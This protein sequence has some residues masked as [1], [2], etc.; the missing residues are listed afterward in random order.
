[1]E[2]NGDETRVEMGSGLVP[3]WN[4][5]TRECLND[6]FS[7]LT[8]EQRWTGPMLVCKTLMNVCQDPSLNTIVDL[9]TPFL[10]IPESIDLWTC[11]FEAK[12]DSILR[13]VVDRSEGGVTEIRVRHCTNQSLSYVAERCPNLEVLWVKYCPNVTDTSMMKIASNCPMLRELDISYSYGISHK[14]LKMFGMKCKNLQVMKKNLVDPSEFTR[15]EHTGLVPLLYSDIPAPPSLGD[16]V[17]IAVGRHMPQLKHLELQYSTITRESVVVL[18]RGCPNLEYVDILGCWNL[19]SRDIATQF[20]SLKNATIKDLVSLLIS[21]EHYLSSLYAHIIR[22]FKSRV[23]G[24]VQ[25]YE[26]KVKEIT[27]KKKL[28]FLSS[29]GRKKT[30]QFSTFSIKMGSRRGPDWSELIRECLIDIFSRLSTEQKWLGPMLVCKNWKNVCRDPSLNSVFDVE[31][32]FLSATDSSICWSPEFE[33]NIDSSLRSVVD[34]SQGGLKEIRVRHCT[35]QSISYVAERCPNLEVLWVK[36]SPNVTIESM[37]QIALNCPKLKEL[38]VSCSCEISCECIEMLGKNCKNL[39]IL[40]RNMMDPAEVVTTRFRSRFVPNTYLQATFFTLGNFDA[41]AIGRHLSQLK[42]L[43]LRFSTM[44][45]IGLLHLCG[46]SKLEYLDLSGC[47]NL[48]SD[49]VTNHIS[50]L[51]NLKEIKKPVFTV[52]FF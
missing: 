49:G 30:I 8:M 20:S 40:K 37:R 10:S 19:A 21:F 15:F 4:E 27:L 23:S 38:D 39:E 46:C 42:H 13:C 22:L 32:W 43:E 48:T 9:E 44:T 51:K 5:L 2:V 33:E 1:M 14:S 29:F 35:N 16:R 28:L 45:D 52:F 11:E 41:R 34:L 26:L 18:C 24:L 36:Y 25:I 50:S 7:R 12:V 6:I 17:A 47:R 31:A 3:E